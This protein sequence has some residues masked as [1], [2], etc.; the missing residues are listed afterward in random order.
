[1]DKEGASKEDWRI[2]LRLPKRDYYFIQGLVEEGEYANAADVIRDAVKHFRANLELVLLPEAKEYRHF[3][4]SRKK[5]DRKILE[6]GLRLIQVSCCLFIVT[7]E[8]FICSTML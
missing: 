5:L 7:K 4:F 1:M 8:K 6:I 3:G 2:T